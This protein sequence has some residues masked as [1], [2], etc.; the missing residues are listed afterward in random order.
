MPGVAIVTDSTADFAGPAAAEL[1]VTIV[2]LTVNWGKDVL[3]DKIDVDTT[4]FYARLR[5]DRDLPH[6]AAPPVGIFEEVFRNLLG[7]HD[8]VISIHIAARLSATYEA[9]S[10]AA[11]GVDAE[12]IHVVDSTTLSV[13]L[14][15]L[16]QRAAKMAAEDQAADAILPVV[17]ALTPRLRLYVTLETLEYLQRG[18]RIGRAQAFLGGLLNVKPV[19]EVRDGEVRPIERVRT[20][21]ASIRRVAEIAHEAGPKE[22]VA[23]VHGDCETEA[24]ALAT[25]LARREGSRLVPLAEL[26]AVLATHAGP[27]VIGVGCILAA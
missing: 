1:G 5:T 13:G 6:T 4:A 10:S 8:E 24:H 15:W 26:G 21:N 9:A 20:R 23:V 27:G 22:L 17:R 11:R 2:P 14:G 7:S 12:R 19:L 25:D 16:V 18:G 3:R